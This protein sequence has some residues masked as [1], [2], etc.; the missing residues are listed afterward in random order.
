MLRTQDDLIALAASDNLC[1]VQD[2]DRARVV[3]ANKAALAVFSA[4]TAEEFY[5][6]D[7]S[8][9]SEA[10]R[11]RLQ[12][13][14]NRVSTGEVYTTQWTTFVKASQPLTLIAE[15]SGYKLEDGRIALLFNARDVGEMVCAESLRMLE[16]SRQSFV[17]YALF[18]Y[19]GQILERNAAHLRAFGD[20][21]GTPA[22]TD[23]FLALFEDKTVAERVRAHTMT[24][25]KYRERVRLVSAQGLCW[26]LLI[27]L[28]I[29]D[30][31]TGDRVLH[32][33]TIDVSAEVEAEERA[34]SAELLLEQIA[35][36]MPQPIAYLR[37]DGYFGFVNRTYANW[38]GKTRDQIVGKHLNE[39]TSQRALTLIQDGLPNIQRGERFQYERQATVAGMGERWISV[40]LIPHVD[41]DGNISGSFIFGSDIH[42][43]KEAE[44]NQRQSDRQLL[45]IA[46]NLPVAVALFDPNHRLQFANR[47]FCAWFSIARETML[48]RHAIEIFGVEAFEGTREARDAAL[49]GETANFRRQTNLHGRQRTIDV[50]LSPYFP[51]HTE[52]SGFLAVYT[53]ITKNLEADL[54]LNLTRDALT[55]HIANTPLC[56]IQ[57]DAALKIT[58]WTGRANEIFG[59]P[60]D[61]ASG[62]RLDELSLFE[63]DAAEQFLVE[64]EKLKLGE[65]ERFTALLRARRRDGATM[66]GEWFGSV[67]RQTTRATNDNKETVVMSYFLLVQDVSARV[68][69]EHHLQY[70][71]N[72][73]A[74]T[75]LPNRTQFQE[76]LRQE[77]ARARR[78]SHRVAVFMVDLDRF[79][80]VNESL[81]HNA[82]DMLLQEVAARLATIC[83]D[84]D[85]VA[86]TGGDEFMLLAEL[87]DEHHVARFAES[88]QRVASRPMVVNGQEIFVTMSIG[89]SVFPDDADVEQ[90]LVKNADWALYRAKDAGR[91]TAQFYSRTATNDTP[92]RLSI[93]T[94]LRRVVEN[95]QLELHY[96][97]KQSMVNGRIT[98][99][100]ALLRWRHPVKGLIQP[101]QFITLA[102]ETGLIIEIGRWVCKEACRQA[103]AWRLEFGATPQIAIN[104]SPMQLSRRELASEILADIA[105]AGIPGGAI[106]IEITE[107]GVVSDPYLASLTL[108]TL[109]NHGV[110]AAI[111]DFGKGYSSLTQLKRLPIDA[112][113]IDS[114]FVRDVVTDRDDA[115][116]IQ[117]IVG[118]GRSLELD[119]IA[120]GVET[121]EQMSLLLKYGCDQVQG[122]FV[123]RPIP[124]QDF[125]ATFLKPQSLG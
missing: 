76:R 115:A 33:E 36:E 41:A 20:S 107:T 49:Q 6:R 64:L 51:K 29:M 67:L 23:E 105:E 54:A 46:D 21:I 75:G 102:E 22:T 39:I 122:Y 98:G 42:A 88:I 77:V 32:V 7:V 8:P 87:D 70:V 93:E 12:I 82:G 58:H 79:K 3:W 52:A 80:Y 86:R 66:H 120:E 100:E 73:D 53:D 114:S 118:L 104:I 101:D 124:P 83:H 37:A 123:S 50:T 17:C 63:A 119:I 108:E 112:L 10:S 26:Y 31:V 18:T 97:P 111:D 65:T 43:L 40:D 92:S 57:L 59:W 13:Y 34:R 1:W 35:D 56:V 69:A 113:K 84:D 117:A 62:R 125:A 27:A 81:G 45:S 110:Q 25:G 90:E 47:A 121:A 96:Q 106:M 95:K 72:H 5:A 74:L 19:S 11:T 38:S 85:F 48:G 15:V 30:P 116:I 55:R 16:A 24:T 14:R 4:A 109:R 99:V 2:I 9:L 71:S 44:E 91:N 89:V 103:A 61:M 94:D 68:T 60:E 78:H 28:A